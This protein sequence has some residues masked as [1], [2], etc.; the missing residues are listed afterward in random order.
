M[1]DKSLLRIGVFYDGTY[2]TLAQ[3]HYYHNRKLGWLSFF[4]LHQLIENFLH[5]R[6]QGY[7]NYRVV[8]S[9]WYQGLFTSTKAS[10]DQL[11][12]DRNTHHDLMHAGIEP[13]FSPMSLSKSEKGTDVAMALDILQIAL[14]DKIDVA[15]I[16]TGDGDFVP[17]A[18]ALMKIGVRVMT[19]YFEYTE[20][21]NKSFINERLSNACNYQLN[22]SELEKSKD[23]GSQTNFKSLFRKNYD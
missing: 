17:L 14:D 18:R 12:F 20:G 15:T 7:S 6:E 16:V 19:V 13:K 9:G 8:C 11:K 3:K 23:R 22:I 21:N 5:E 2:F 10:F 4:P 1:S